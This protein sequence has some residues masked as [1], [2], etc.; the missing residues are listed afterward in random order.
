MVVKY[1]VQRKIVVV[2]VIAG[3]AVRVRVSAYVCMCV[4]K[5]V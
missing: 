5:C 1:T 4:S 2:F 3:V